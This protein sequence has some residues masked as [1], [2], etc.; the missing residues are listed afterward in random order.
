[1]IPL[2]SSISCGPLGVCQLPRLWW[3]VQLSA[4]GKLDSEYPEC[5]GG[6]DSQVISRLGLERDAVLAHLHAERPDYLTFEAWVVDQVG[7]L[8]RADLEAWNSGIRSRVHRPE[9][10]EAIPRSVGLG[11]AAGITSA[12]ILNHLEDWHYFHRQLGAG[13]DPLGPLISTIDYGPLGVCQLPRTWLKVVLEANGRL[14]T[15]YPACGGGLDTRA[16]EVLGLERGA[17]VDYLSRSPSYLDFESW[18]LEQRGGDLDRAAIDEWNAYVNGREHGAE[19]R[20]HIQA[21]IG[22]DL[23]D[24]TSAVVLNHVE[25][26]HLAFSEGLRRGS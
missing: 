9:K 15:D 23:G 7:E 2:I 1:M 8:D 22:R 6:L 26:W 14:H 17:A 24:T 19:K 21:T 13:S 11:D 10:L 25:D 18:V 4:A 3:K 5:S 20:A 16:L 12:V